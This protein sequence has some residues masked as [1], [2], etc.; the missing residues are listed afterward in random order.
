M[1]HEAAPSS[2]FGPQDW[3]WSHAQKL[4]IQW[5]KK[6]MNKQKKDNVLK[7]I[8]FIFHFETKKPTVL[9][10]IFHYWPLMQRVSCMC[11]GPLRLL[12]A[13]DRGQIVVQSKSRWDPRR[14]QMS[15]QNK[16]QLTTYF[17]ALGKTCFFFFFFFF[18]L[19]A[20]LKYLSLG[21]CSF[22]YPPAW[23]PKCPK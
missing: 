17:F 7:D 4:G 11:V 21:L 20:L 14:L 12:L 19:T 6:I 3:K 22:C 10:L 8:R 5:T 13:D 15:N 1:S 16:N 9:V 18:F 2:P 23:N